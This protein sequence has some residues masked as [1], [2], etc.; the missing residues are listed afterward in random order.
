MEGCGNSRFYH[1]KQQVE[2]DETGSDHQIGQ[3]K[4]KP[5]YFPGII[6]TTWKPDPLIS[7][8]FLRVMFRETGGLDII[9]LWGIVNRLGTL[10]RN[11]QGRTRLR[12]GG[13]HAYVKSSVK[14]GMAAR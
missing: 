7:A 13:I 9:G 1:G 14:F 5:R 6:L 3:I 4:R 12:T 2:F 10:G 11:D 8:Y